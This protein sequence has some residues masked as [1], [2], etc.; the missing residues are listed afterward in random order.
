MTPPFLMDVLIWIDLRIYR[1]DHKKKY[2]SLFLFTF[3]LLLRE[4]DQEIQLSEDLFSGLTV[5]NIVFDALVAE[6]NDESSLDFLQLKDIAD[7]SKGT[8]CSGCLVD[9]ED[10]AEETGLLLLLTD[11]L[12]V[13]V[14]FVLVD[15]DDPFLF[16]AHVVDFYHS[17]FLIPRSFTQANRHVRLDNRF[18]L[19]E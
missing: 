18:L 2:G 9:S 19:L 16:D 6:G 3:S 1:I 5:S 11:L 7:E 17:E 13:V 15:T 14:D 10:L 8:L 4:V 12:V